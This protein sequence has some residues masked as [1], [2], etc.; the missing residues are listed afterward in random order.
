MGISNFLFQDAFYHGEIFDNIIDSGPDGNGCG[1]PHGGVDRHDMVDS[2]EE[3][4][5]LMI[6]IE[7]G[8]HEDISEHNSDYCKLQECFHLSPP[9]GRN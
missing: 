3:S 2:I 1:Q 6:M 4:K 8:Q 7:C 5:F 9:G